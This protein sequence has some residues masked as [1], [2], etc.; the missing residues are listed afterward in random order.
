MRFFGLSW[1][2]ARSSFGAMISRGS[3]GILSGGGYKGR[4]AG[5]GLRV[6]LETKNRDRSTLEDGLACRLGEVPRRP[7]DGGEGS[8]AA[9]HEEIHVDLRIFG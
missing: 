6:P 1:G 2:S 4:D 5:V 7:P 8:S 3:S 9:F